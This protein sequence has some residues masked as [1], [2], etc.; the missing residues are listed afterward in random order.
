MKSLILHQTKDSQQYNLQKTFLGLKKI[1]ASFW[2][3]F[4]LFFSFLDYFDFV[5]IHGMLVT[6]C[7]YIL[8]ILL[9]LTESLEKCG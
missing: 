7:P 6:N 5:G 2:E 3:I 9:S 1:N 8:D 4:M